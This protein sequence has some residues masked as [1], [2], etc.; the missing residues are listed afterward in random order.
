MAQHRDETTRVMVYSAIFW[1]VFAITLGLIQAIEFIAPDSFARDRVAG[2]PA[3]PAG[4]RQRTGLRLALDGDGGRLVLH[5]AA[6]DQ[7][8][9]LLGDAGHR[10]RLG[11]E[12]RARG[13]R[14][15]ADARL[16]AGSRVRR[17]GVAHRHRDHGGAAADRLQP[18]HDHRAPQGEGPLRVALVRDGHAHL[19]PHRLRDRQRDL[20]APDRR[21]HGPQRRDL[22]LVLRPQHP[23]PVVHDRHRRAHLLH[24]AARR[25]R[26]R[27]TATRSRSSPSGASRSSTPRSART[28]SWAHRCPSGSRPSRSSAR[29]AC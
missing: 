16:D 18:V 20:G 6:A 7:V 22:E 25:S 13:R 5:R 8:R 17:A 26:S 14:G 21:A 29:S 1:L 9:D 12:H 24:R 19:V 4:A 10:R 23:G 2:L 15:R 11:V 28:T 27:S 3:H